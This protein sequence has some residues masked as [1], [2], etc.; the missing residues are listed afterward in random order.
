MCLIHAGGRTQDKTCI[1]QQDIARTLRCLPVLVQSC[2]KLLILCGESY[3]SRLWCAWELYVHFAMSG[4]H[5]SKRTTI[6]DCRRRRRTDTHTN[7]TKPHQ[8]QHQHEQQEQPEVEQVDNPSAVGNP[9]PSGAEPPPAAAAVQR[10]KGPAEELCKFSVENAHC[11]S[12]ED[13]ARLR[14]VI[15]SEGSETFNHAIREAGE[16]VVALQGQAAAAGKHLELQEQFVA[17]DANRDGRLDRCDLLAAFGWDAADEK[18][19]EEGLAARSARIDEL[20]E[21]INTEDE[22][23]VNGGLSIGEAEFRQWLARSA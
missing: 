20:L 5:A 19:G 13:E 8:H 11:F 21:I 1:N 18:E 14:R 10:S 6:V 15:E 16:A 4:V 23:R 2:S 3:A 12:P 9:P 7:A 22:L 17:L